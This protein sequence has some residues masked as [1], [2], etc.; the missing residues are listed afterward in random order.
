MNKKAFDQHFN[1]LLGDAEETYSFEEEDPNT[2]QP[3]KRVHWDFWGKSVIF[4]GPEE[5]IK[6]ALCKRRSDYS[7]FT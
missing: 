6:H 1:C 3:V 2:K 4:L 7:H 5:K